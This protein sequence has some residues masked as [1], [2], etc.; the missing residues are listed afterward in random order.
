MCFL[1]GENI[2]ALLQSQVRNIANFLLSGLQTARSNFV[3]KKIPFEQ[4]MLLFLQSFYPFCSLIL[5][6]HQIQ[7][8][9]VSIS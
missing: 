9:I 5:I 3:L 7:Y 4:K 1:V 8:D 6:I 2:Q